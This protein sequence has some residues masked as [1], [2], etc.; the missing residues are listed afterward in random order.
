MSQQINL[1]HADLKKS[2]QAFSVLNMA[3]GLGVILFLAIVFYG[4]VAYQT[5]Q[6]EQELEAANKNLAAEQ[7][8]LT[9]LSA[10]FARQRAGVSLEQEVKK[11]SAE[12]A[13]QRAVINALK[14]G[15]IGNTRGYSGYMRAFAKQSV[16]GLWLT[17]FAIEGDAKQMS[18][19]GATLSPDL[20]P[21]YILRLNHEAA[22]R[23]K[24]FTSLNMQLPKT[25]AAKPATAQYLE[26]VLR[27][28]AG[29][30]AEKSGADK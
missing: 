22:M 7:A 1:F 11:L 8:K 3:Q 23:G 5:R 13:A 24:T 28:D 18:I 19:S 4:Y 27:S 16:N 20:V 26:F 17:G 25:D 21:A 15:E 2:G 29:G 12:A 6:M 9:E 14:D 10:E 30:D